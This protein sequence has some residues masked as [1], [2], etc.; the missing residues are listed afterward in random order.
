MHNGNNES[1]NEGPYY[2]PDILALAGLGAI[3]DVRNDCK[4]KKAQKQMNQPQT[5]T[6]IQMFE[7]HA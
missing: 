3:G 6:L 1:N 4:G 7:I 2:K 5:A